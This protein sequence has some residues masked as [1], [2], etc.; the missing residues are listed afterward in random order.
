MNFLGFIRRRCM[1]RFF[2]N[3]FQNFGWWKR[4]GANS[5][6]LK[7]I[8]YASRSIA[9]GHLVL[10]EGQ[11]QHASNRSGMQV[12][13]ACTIMCLFPNY[14]HP[15]HISKLIVWC[16]VS[17]DQ[18]AILSQKLLHTLLSV[19]IAQLTGQYMSKLCIYI[20]Q[21]VRTT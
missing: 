2:R 11:I 5:T 21:Q 7:Q 18:S 3:Y 15:W 1:E 13:H 16:I 17:V 10:S 19:L 9:L 4:S 14:K 6:H 12:I 8:T 20:R